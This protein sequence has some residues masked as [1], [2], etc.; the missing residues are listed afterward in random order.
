MMKCSHG[1]AYEVKCSE[2]FS[3]AMQKAG[4]QSNTMAWQ[5]SVPATVTPERRL[6]PVKMFEGNQK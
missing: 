5:K 1:L 3:E 2:C 6:F 4:N